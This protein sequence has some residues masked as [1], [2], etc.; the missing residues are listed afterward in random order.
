MKNVWVLA[1]LIISVASCADPEPRKPVSSSSSTF[2]KESVQRNKAI[3]EMEEAYINQRI[4][5]DSLATYHNSEQGFWF[6]YIR[7]NNESTYTAQTG[8]I[9][10]IT[11]N[12]QT[13]DGDILYSKETIDTVQYKVDKQDFLFQGLRNAVKIL[14]PGE[15]AVFF[16]PSS[17]AYGYVGDHKKIGINIPL[18]SNLELLSIQHKQDSISN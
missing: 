17:L 1:L 2:F 6:K 5:D 16:F 8:D 9:A 3:L 10:I 4:S 7:K 15:E 14:K 13:I 12:I 11:Y 18:K